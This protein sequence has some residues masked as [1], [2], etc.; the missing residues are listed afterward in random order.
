[1]DLASIISTFCFNVFHHSNITRLSW[2][3]LRFMDII[4]ACVYCLVRFS[5]MKCKFLE[6]VF[7]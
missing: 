4:Y 1:M 6:F 7:S 3:Y 5:D 2:D